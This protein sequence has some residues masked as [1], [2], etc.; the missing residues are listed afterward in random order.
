MHP[1]S[2]PDIKHFLRKILN[3]VTAMV[4][5]AFVN[6]FL[7]LY[8]EWGIINEGGFNI[9]NGIFYVFFIGSLVAL[10]YYFYKVWKR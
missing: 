5:W 6:M 4:S 2:E 8:L 7:G 1:G 10:I 9:L 3:V